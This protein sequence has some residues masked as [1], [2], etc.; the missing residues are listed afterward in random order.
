ML[1]VSMLRIFLPPM[2]GKRNKV[3]VWFLK[4]CRHG[5]LP[6][7]LESF[8]YL[9]FLQAVPCDKLIYSQLV[10]DWF[11]SLMNHI[12]Q[13]MLCQ[14]KPSL[15]VMREA[16]FY[17]KVGMNLEMSVGVQNTYQMLQLQYLRWI[18]MNPLVFIDVF[19][20]LIIQHCHK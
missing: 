5:R 9:Y 4:K 16:A 6:L 12:L 13:I 10:L 2:R 1:W 17:T 18:E 20:Y 7:V 8:I 19:L 3:T 11:K 15:W 14:W